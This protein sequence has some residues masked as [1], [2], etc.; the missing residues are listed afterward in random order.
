[1]VVYVVDMVVLSAKQM[2]Y[3]HAY[4]YL[5]SYPLAPP[6]SVN[7]ILIFFFSHNLEFRG[8]GF[9]IGIPSTNLRIPT[10]FAI[11]ITLNKNLF[12]P[13]LLDYNIA[14]GWRHSP[15]FAENMPNYPNPPGMTT[16][17]VFHGVVLP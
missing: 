9:N 7:D 1:M 16:L 3:L 5:S 11:R 8:F 17:Q 13:N 15:A 6:K 12:N 14:I 4:L 2:A 10:S